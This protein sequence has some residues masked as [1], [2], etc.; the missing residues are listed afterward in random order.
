MKSSFAVKILFL[1]AAV[2]LSA[3]LGKITICA[4]TSPASKQNQSSR[5]QKQAQIV[6]TTDPSPAQKG[7][8]TVRVKLT[9][10]AGRP[11]EGAQV[12]ITFF[13]PAM[14]SM[15]MAA[16]KTVIKATSKGGGI[17]EGKGDLRSAGRWQVTIAA[18]QGGKTIVTKRLTVNVTG[19]M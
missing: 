10:E 18:H 19:G 14:P 12:S 16:M 6:L 17:Y 15:G 11:I 13:M 8:N 2:A 1:L 5:T 7:R 9:N 3:A 4:Q